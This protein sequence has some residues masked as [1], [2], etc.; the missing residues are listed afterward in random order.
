MLLAVALLVSLLATSCGW[1]VYA[2]ESASLS[3]LAVIGCIVAVTLWWL[4]RHGRDERKTPTV[5]AVMASAPG[6]LVMAIAMTSCAWPLSKRA[7]W[8]FGGDHVRH[9]VYVAQLHADGVL[10]YATNPYPRAWHALLALVWSA[11]GGSADIPG[12]LL[13]IEGMSL[14]VWLLHGLLS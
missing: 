8:F 9:I 10:D 14:A 6:L 4:V 3:A 12:I 2:S 1:R 5:T 13:L 7:E 11:A